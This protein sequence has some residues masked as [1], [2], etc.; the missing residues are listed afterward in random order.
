MWLENL[1]VR[2]K[3][4]PKGWAV[5]TQKSRR[6]LLF[7]TV[8][9]WVHIEATSGM[10]DKPWYYKTKEMAISEAVKHFEWDLIINTENLS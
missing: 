3:Q 7:F 6:F 1:K 8:N 10:A 5:E 9:Y 4:Y 2:V